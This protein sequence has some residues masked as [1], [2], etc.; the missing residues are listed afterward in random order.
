MSTPVRLEV[1]GKAHTWE[2]RREL[3]PADQARMLEALCQF[4]RILQLWLEA[5]SQPPHP[6][7]LPP[8][9]RG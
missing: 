9:E 2:I 4:G 3:S 7:P 8:G 6:S 1:G 5:E